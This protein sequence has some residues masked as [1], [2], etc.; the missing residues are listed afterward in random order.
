MQLRSSEMVMSMPRARFQGLQIQV[1]SRPLK[2]HEQDHYTLQMVLSRPLKE[3]EQDHY[4]LQ[5]VSSK[6]LKEHEQDHYILQMVSSRPLK[7][8]EQDHYTLQMAQAQGTQAQ[9]ASLPKDRCESCGRH[10]KEPGLPMRKKLHSSNSNG[11]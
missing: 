6:P 7:E 4:T 3:H 9:A 1:L 11:N 2:E 10:W 5:M 8:H